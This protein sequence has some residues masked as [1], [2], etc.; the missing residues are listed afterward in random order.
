[1]NPQL[2]IAQQWL[3]LIDG[4]VGRLELDP[5]PDRVTM[6]KR[7]WNSQERGVWWLAKPCPK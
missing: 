6:K 2:R 3:V 7:S 1:M 4:A 5:Q